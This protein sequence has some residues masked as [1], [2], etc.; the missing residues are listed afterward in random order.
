VSNEL[1]DVEVLNLKKL[2]EEGVVEVT[3]GYLPFRCGGLRLETAA[4]K[5]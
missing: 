5:K 1:Y 4:V 3:H 2:R